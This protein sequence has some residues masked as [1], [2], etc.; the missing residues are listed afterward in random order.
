[1]GTTKAYI[2]INVLDYHCKIIGYLGDGTFILYPQMRWKQT[3]KMSVGLADFSP[4]KTEQIHC[5]EN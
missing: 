4:R 2:Y 1:M 5:G 3:D